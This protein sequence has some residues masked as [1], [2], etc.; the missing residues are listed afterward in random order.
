MRNHNRSAR[1]EYRREAALAG[2]AYE[3]TVAP[4]R[5][6]HLKARGLSD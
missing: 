2:E 1:E 3:E 5:E 6:A 4:A